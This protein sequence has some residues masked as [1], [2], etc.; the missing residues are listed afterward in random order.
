MATLTMSYSR[1]DTRWTQ[2]ATRSTSIM[3]QRIARLPWLG[4]AFALCWIGWTPMEVANVASARRIYEGLARRIPVCF[5]LPTPPPQPC[6][7]Y[8][9]PHIQGLLRLRA[10]IRLA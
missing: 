9:T 3:E 2:M 1:V 6:V 4:P 5:W 7:H 8:Q 10:G